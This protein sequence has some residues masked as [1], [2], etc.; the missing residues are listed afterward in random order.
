[1]KIKEYRFT[2]NF[3]KAANKYSPKTKKLIARKIDLF[4]ADPFSLELKTH[5]LSG[6]LNGYYSFSVNYSITRI[7]G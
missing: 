6:K 3:K 2:Q 1:M 5:P 4:V 7:T